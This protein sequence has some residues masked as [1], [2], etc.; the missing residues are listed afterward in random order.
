LIGPGGGGGG[1]ALN[2]NIPTA[3]KKQ[4]LTLKQEL[5]SLKKFSY[6]SGS[7]AAQ[8]QLPNRIGRSTASPAVGNASPALGMGIHEPP[9]SAHSVASAPAPRR[10]HSQSPLRH[11]FNSTIHSSPARAPARAK[12]ARHNIPEYGSPARHQ[13][14][15]YPQGSTDSHSAGANSTYESLLRDLQNAQARAKMEADTLRAKAG[16]WV[17]QL[18]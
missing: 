16:A 11:D 2:H 8:Q 9:K 4:E 10:T 12:P 5:D 15:V 13:F 17:S 7:N 3:P 18:L 6:F 14:G 1:V